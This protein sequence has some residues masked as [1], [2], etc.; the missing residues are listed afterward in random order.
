MFST[1]RTR[2][3]IPGVIS[4]I[5]LVFA[6]L[7]G[8][9]AA[10]KSADSGKA[11]ASAKTKRGPQG[12]KGATGPA[13]PQGV[14]GD[15]GSNGAN[16]KDGQSVTGA[17]IPVGDAC[18]PGIGNTGV[19]YTLGGTSTEICNGRNGSNGAN[20][21]SVVVTPESPGANCEGGGVK[22]A[23]QNTP[24]QSFVCNGKEGSGGGGGGGFPE[25][26]P[27]GKTE[28]GTWAQG[29]N[30]GGLSLVPLTFNIPLEEAPELHFVNAAGE[31]RSDEAPPGT[32][33]NCFGSPANPTAPPGHLCI[34]AAI[35]EGGTFPGYVNLTSTFRSGAIFPYEAANGNFAWGTWA[36]TAPEP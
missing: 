6:M 8:A 33:E 13:G 24:G 14:K 35:Q 9:W 1:L 34:Y 2:F 20:G 21:N 10:S 5:A 18:G 26:L 36:V 16:G 29:F 15:N 7:G 22:V 12:P 17:S 19:K 32:V 4:V 3:G 11:T 28:T 31:E 30:D 25:T 27:A 23:V